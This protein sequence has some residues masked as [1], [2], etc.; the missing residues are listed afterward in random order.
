MRLLTM[1]AAGGVLL[2]ASA[3]ADDVGTRKAG[4]WQV[5]IIGA[6]GKA[7]PPRTLC[8][9]PGRPDDLAKHMDSC[10]KME[11]HKDGNTTTVDAVCTKGGSQ[12]TA[13]SA[14]TATSENEFHAES[15]ATYTPPIAGMGTMDSVS[16]SKW[17]GPCPAGQ[18][19][20][21]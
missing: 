1:L 5:T 11:I 18:R 10:S 13:H 20:V 7:Q 3:Q 6:D 4:Q 17:L 15:H 12:I 2:A 16:D 21:N 9:G 19:P 8:L 14:F